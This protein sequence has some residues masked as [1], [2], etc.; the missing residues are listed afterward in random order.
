MSESAGLTFWAKN[1][2]QPPNS[3]A[4]FESELDIPKKRYARGEI[5]QAEFEE[6]RRDVRE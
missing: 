2:R 5:S 6:M 3:A 1:E 4:Q